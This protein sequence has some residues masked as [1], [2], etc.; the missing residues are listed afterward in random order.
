M[1]VGKDEA[2]VYN[3]SV[4]VFER[5]RM[6]RILVAM[7][8]VILAAGAWGCKEREAG[9][10]ENRSAVGDEA[11]DVMSFNIRYG[12]ARDGE[13]SWE[14]RREMVCE[15]VRGS[16]A[17]VVGVQEALGFQL[18][19]IAEVLEGYQWVGVGREDGKA[20]GEFSAILYDTRRF[21]AVEGG[22]FWLSETPEVTGS[23][24]WKTACERI[25]TWVRL[26]EKNGGNGFYV[27]NTHF[28]HVS[29]LAREKGAVLIAGR[30]RE[31]ENQEPFI[32]MGDLNA[33][34]D[35]RVIRFLKGDE[36]IDGGKVGVKMVDS[37]RVVKPD[38]KVVGTTS[39]FKGRTNGAKIDYVFVGNGI[40]VLDAEIV[41]YNLDGRYLSDH[42]P[43]RAKIEFAK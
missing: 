42:Y 15:F 38:E 34:E 43:V 33:G 37:Y 22:T 20:K 17:E 41:R 3:A 10:F 31:R 32:L 26:V 2:M 27:F 28:D 24:S 6:N 19:T 7:G 5:D 4:I 13:N 8:L 1:F 40:E 30:I 29:Q 25:C 12:T 21:D 23:K 11:I 35:N 14:Y 39:G 18:E 9:Q 16:G 36:E